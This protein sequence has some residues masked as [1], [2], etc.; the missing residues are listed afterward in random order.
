M[1]FYLNFSQNQ[2]AKITGLIL[3]G[4]SVFSV[5]VMLHHPTVSS[6]SIYDQIDELNHHARLNTS[7]HG[8]LISFIILI[9]LCLTY[10]SKVRGLDRSSVL[11]GVIIYWVGTVVMV[12]AALMSGVVSPELAGHYQQAS[13]NQAESFTGMSLLIHEINQAFAYFSVFCWCAGIAFWAF[14]M[15]YQVRLI[16]LFGL[17]SLLAAFVIALS[18]LFSWVALTVSGVTVILIVLSIWQLG[19]AGMLYVHSVSNDD[20]V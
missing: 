5:W 10:Y 7:V 20:V 9:S 15:F 12:L 14:D 1:S 6:Q 13:L 17:V 3:A 11:Y 16:K 8:V 2:Q 19:I 18:L 4:I